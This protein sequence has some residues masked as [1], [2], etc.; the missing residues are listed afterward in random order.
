MYQK[1]LP[2]KLKLY[3]TKL[4]TLF[5]ICC[6]FLLESIL[7]QLPFGRMNTTVI[8]GRIGKLG[9]SLATTVYVPFIKP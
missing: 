8:N 6:L 1:K 5:Q 7:I 9:I 3:V 4:N 2:G